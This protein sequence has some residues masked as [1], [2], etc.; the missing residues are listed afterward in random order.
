MITIFKYEIGGTTN[1]IELP[2]GAEVL[3][4]ELQCDTIFMWAK[5]N[6][7]AKTEIRNFAVFGTGHKMPYDMGVDY[8]FIG[9]VHTTHGLVFHVFERLGL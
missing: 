5:I 9:T 2:E 8:K 6:T 7:E 3:S 1:V 4:V